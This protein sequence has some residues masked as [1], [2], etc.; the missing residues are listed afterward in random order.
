M[1]D[2]LLKKPHALYRF[3]DTNGAL[4]YVGISVNL[5]S[6]LSTHIKEK[7]WWHDVVQVTVEMLPDRESALEAEKLAIRAERPLYNVQHN[8]VS[9]QQFT[10]SSSPKND[11]ALDG[12]DLIHWTFR[13]RRSGYE[14]TVPLW[15]AWEINCSSISDDYFIEEIPARYLYQEW[16]RRYPKDLP[17]EE[18]FGRGAV[19]IWWF[20]QGPGVM[21]YAPVAGNGSS[22]WS[23]YYRSQPFIS[24]HDFLHSFT[25]PSNDLVGSLQW[26]R[27]PIIDQVWRKENLPKLY[28]T[29]GG[30][31]QEATGWK[32]SPFQP[33][34]DIN[35]LDL[36]SE[37]NWL[38]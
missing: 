19:S 35:Y 27:L 7:E 11:G 30:F 9:L 4:L 31:I 25:W 22:V 12:S 14:R 8:L 17:A 37:A 26:T 36:L 13:S 32:P 6:R 24:S 10:G 38:P 29:K 3:F 2:L 1:M 23:K 28:S 33:Y 16:R 20:I 18:A 5:P 21:E 34:I 15:L